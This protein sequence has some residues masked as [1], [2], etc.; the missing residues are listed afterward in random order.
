[1]DRNQDLSDELRN[2]LDQWAEDA[3]GGIGI[4]KDR[5]SDFE[6]W[7]DKVIG[8]LRSVYTDKTINMFLR[9]KDN[10]K[11]D[12]PDGFARVTGSCGDTMEIFLKVDK[13]VISDSS[14]QTDGCNPSKAS[15]GMVAYMV[16][17]KSI[18]IVQ[19]LTPED[20]LD[21]LGGLPEENEHCAS[22]AVDTLKKA[23][24]DMADR[25]KTRREGH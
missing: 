3:L 22:L 17:G 8:Q 4:F 19:R 23:L 15:G 7:K 5:F 12:S 6:S 1:M 9:T 10:R 21:E 25:G 2:A 24:E 16:R 20:I 18:D 11:I 14:F 13:G